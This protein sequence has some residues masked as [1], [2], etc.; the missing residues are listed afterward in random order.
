[1]GSNSDI[2]TLLQETSELSDWYSNVL[3]KHNTLENV[4]QWDCGRPTALQE[5]TRDSDDDDYQD[6]DY[7]VATLANN[8]SQAFRYD[9]YN[10]NDNEEVS[11][12]LQYMFSIVLTLL[13][14]CSTK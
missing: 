11:T 8:L 6:K 3:L 14:I 7:D 2:Q 1:M 12:M 9:I 10:N 5:R 13:C 4:Y